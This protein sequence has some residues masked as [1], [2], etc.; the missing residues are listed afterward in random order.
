MKLTIALLL[1]LGLAVPACVA[2][3]VKVAPRF[4]G[5]SLLDHFKPAPGRTHLERDTA[6]ME[7]YERA[8]G[9]LDGISDATEGA[10][11]CHSG[12]IKSGEIDSDVVAALRKLPPETLKTNASVLITDILRKRF[13]CA[14]PIREQP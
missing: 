8:R 5:Q 7:S 9:Y 4:T 1:C 13:P 2:Q 6:S 10:A 3:S 11:W 12:Q 14:K